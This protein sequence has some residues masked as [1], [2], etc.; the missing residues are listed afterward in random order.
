[1]DRPAVIVAR[2]PEEP[3]QSEEPY[4]QERPEEPCEKAGPER[5]ESEKLLWR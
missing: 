1:M 2:M 3:G 5:P 4:E